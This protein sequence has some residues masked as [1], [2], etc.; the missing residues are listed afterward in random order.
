MLDWCPYTRRGAPLVA[1]DAQVTHFHQARHIDSTVRLIAMGAVPLCLDPHTAD[2]SS[3]VAL[4]LSV[5]PR[6]APKRLAYPRTAPYFLLLY[7]S[8]SRPIALRIGTTGMVFLGLHDSSCYCLRGHFQ[9]RPIWVI[10]ANWHLPGG[11]RWLPTGRP[12]VLSYDVAYPVLGAK[13]P[14]QL[15]G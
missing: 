9:M 15:F 1:P 2:L 6:R 4:F 7:R 14:F 5:N 8:Y 12:H 11:N 10:Y 3:D 13:N